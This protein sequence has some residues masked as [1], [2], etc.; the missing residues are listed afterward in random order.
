MYDNPCNHCENLKHCRS[1]MDMPMNNMPMMKMPMENMSMPQ[2]DDNNDLKML[3]P[4]MY[5]KIYPMVAHHC[6]MMVAMYGTMYCPSKDEMDDISEQLCDKYEENYRYDYEDD[7]YE[8]DNLMND[9]DMRQRRRRR[10]RPNRRN[11]V[12]DLVKIL[13]IGELIGRRGRS[14]IYNYGY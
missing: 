1:M 13:L 8:Y 11:T 14:P 3:Y 2:V 4:E 5:I 6:D 7:D 12:R 9:N 10:R